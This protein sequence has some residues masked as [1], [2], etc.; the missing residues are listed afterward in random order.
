AAGQLIAR[1]GHRYLLEA[2]S[3]LRRDH[4]QVR[5]VMFGE[6]P[7]DTQLRAQATSLGLGDIVQFAGY[8]DDLDA[9]IGCFDLFVHPASA[10]G[11]GIAVLKA[12]AA[13]LPV[14]ACD[15][16]GLSEIV[17]PGETGVLVPPGDASALQQAIGSLVDDAALRGKLGAAAR[18]RMQNE[19][20]VA[21]MADRHLE[22]YNS[23]I[24]E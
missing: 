8:R 7:L 18:E 6:G 16:G 9:F 1:K 2:I 3:G 23:L 17:V 4:P 10:E 12:S 19:F 21:T 20:S 24:S 15:A 14:V 22:L 5:L 13:G 11:L